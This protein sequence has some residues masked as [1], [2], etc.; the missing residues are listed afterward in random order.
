MTIVFFQRLKL[1]LLCAL[2]QCFVS[3]PSVFFVVSVMSE[4]GAVGAGL[5]DVDDIPL[6][7]EDG[8]DVKVEPVSECR[9]QLQ[10]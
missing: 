6:A 9:T 2:P 4:T 5:A 8:E 3:T 7:D 1:R 10:R